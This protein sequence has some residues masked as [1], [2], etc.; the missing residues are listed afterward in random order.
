MAKTR[1]PCIRNLKCFEES[2]CPQREWDG[3]EGCTAW[4]EM[5]VG[6][7]ETPNVPEMKKQCIDRWQFDFSVSTLGVLEGNQQAIESFRNGM[8]NVDQEGT[9]HPKPD[10]AVLTLIQMVHDQ[11]KKQNIIKDYEE[12]KMI[13]KAKF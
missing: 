6:K 4:V 12:R 13:N 8:L 10:P 1:P 9:V 3:E 11:I 5:M 7:K 2:G